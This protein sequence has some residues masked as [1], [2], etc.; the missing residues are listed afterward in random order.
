MSEFA[1]GRR[2]LLRLLVFAAVGRAAAGSAQPAR[3][4]LPPPPPRKPAA[5][6]PRILP[7]VAIDAGHGGGD[8]GAISSAGL[9]EKDITLAAARL[10]AAELATTRRFRVVLTRRDDEF[11]ALP[12]R[13]ARARAAHA[14]LFLSLHAD[15]LPNPALRGLSVYTLSAAASD[16]EAAALAARENTAGQVAGLDL[17]REPR[18]VGN[19]LFDLARRGTENLSIALARRIV[20]ELGQ[21]TALLERPRRAAGFAV[22]TAPDIPSALVELGCLSNPLEERLLATAAY[23]RRLTRGLAHAVEDYFASFAPGA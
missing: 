19:V 16:R 12:D 13:V 17:S 23:Q 11:V 2:A 22:L 8:P 6:P 9:Y 1:I 10:L 3:N 15:A 7:L 4:R 20:D 18:E 5:P 21:V 14:D